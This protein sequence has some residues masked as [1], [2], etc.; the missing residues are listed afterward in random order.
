MFGVQDLFHV[1]LNNFEMAIFL[2]FFK[3]F[4]IFFL[5]YGCVILKRREP[6]IN[7]FF[8]FLFATPDIAISEAWCFLHRSYTWS[9]VSCFILVF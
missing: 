2:L 9:V 3:L 1:F 6:L 8:T 5:H 7:L 4:I